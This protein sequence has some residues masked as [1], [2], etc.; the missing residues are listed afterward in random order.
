VGKFKQKQKSGMLLVI[1]GVTRI[2]AVVE[3]NMFT[4][5]PPRH[6]LKSDFISSSLLSLLVR[7]LSKWNG[8]LRP[9]GKRLVFSHSTIIAPVLKKHE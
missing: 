6:E 5:D 3:K 8:W 2:A 7:C 1:P 4:F 9:S